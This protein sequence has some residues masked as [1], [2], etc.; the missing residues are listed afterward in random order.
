VLKHSLKS[1]S[2][3]KNLR[4]ETFLLERHPRGVWQGWLRLGGQRLYLCCHKCLIEARV[5]RNQALSECLGQGGLAR[6]WKLKRKPVVV[7]EPEPKPEPALEPKASAG[8]DASGEID[9]EADARLARSLG[10]V[11][12]AATAEVA[13]ETRKLLGL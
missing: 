9:A 12:L 2:C 8:A 3:A 1:T 5:L 13:E 11:P 4:A 10:I 6:A 7:A